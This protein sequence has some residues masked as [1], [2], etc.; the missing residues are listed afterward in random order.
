MSASKGQWEDNI[1]LK[2]V[3]V[4]VQWGT[5]EIFSSLVEMVILRD[6]WRFQSIP[7]PVACGP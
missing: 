6:F 3:Q 1:R 2:G 7:L 4:W 5:L